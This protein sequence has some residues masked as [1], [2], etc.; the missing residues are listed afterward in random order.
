MLPEAGYLLWQQAG[1]AQQLLDIRPAAEFERGHLTGAANLPWPELQTQQHLLPAT[2]RCLWLV[3]TPDQ[4]DAL[5]WLRQRGYSLQAGY[6]SDALKPAARWLSQGPS[7]QQLWRPNPL[8]AE[9]IE[10]IEAEIPGRRAL[11]LACGAGRDSMFLALRGWSL[12]SI[13]YL[14][15]HLD[16]LRRFAQTAQVQIEPCLQD[17]T[18]P[19]ALPAEQD[20]LLVFRYLHR[21]L[22]PRLA[23]LVRPGG[24]LLYQTFQE[25]AQAFGSPKNPNYLLQPNELAAH[26][27]DWQPWLNRVDYLADGRPMQ[28]WLA[29][30]PE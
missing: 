13:D 19:I 3:L 1:A 6:W 15:E 5:D 4:Q 29:R 28:S 23:Q 8:L 7:R 16:K 30:R 24:F 17:L 25:G 22:L 9:V 27:P 20:L 12:T 26:F 21:P 14:P 10:Q 2:D 11:D 18:Q